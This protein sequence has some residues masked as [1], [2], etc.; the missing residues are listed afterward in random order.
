MGRGAR[1]RAPVGWNV[2]LGQMRIDM[3][4]RIR[5]TFID[6]GARTRICVGLCLTLA[7]PKRLV[8]RRHRRES[9]RRQAER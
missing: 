5:Q 7:L 4:V 9:A 1:V 2:G 6:S 8:D 3:C